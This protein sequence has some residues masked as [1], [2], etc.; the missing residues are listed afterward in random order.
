MNPVA[1]LCSL[2]LDTMRWHPSC[3]GG[4]VKALNSLGRLLSLHSDPLPFYL[5]PNSSRSSIFCFLFWKVE[6][7]VWFIFFTYSLRKNTK[8]LILM[9]KNIL[10]HEIFWFQ[11]NFSWKLFWLLFWLEIWKLTSK[12]WI[13]CRKIL[14]SQTH[15][16]SGRHFWTIHYFP[17][18]V[19]FFFFNLIK[20]RIICVSFWVVWKM[21]LCISF[22][23]WLC[24]SDC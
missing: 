7:C 11:V 6:D 15:R 1:W 12:F 9:K 20:G 5:E 13:L 17:Q 22:V 21:C 10:T 24:L 4:P 16:N 3:M 19:Y 8:Q 2:A 23:F 18:A 14:T